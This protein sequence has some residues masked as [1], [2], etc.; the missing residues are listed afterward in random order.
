MQFKQTE[1]EKQA[2]TFSVFAM[3]HI[4]RRQDATSSTR[5]LRPGPVAP[6]FHRREEE[7]DGPT[8]PLGLRQGR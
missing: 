3:L 6:P 5:Q 2:A 8:T 7:T 1:K 4:T